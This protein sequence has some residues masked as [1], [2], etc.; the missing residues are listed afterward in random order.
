MKIQQ[1]S[2]G[3]LF[4]GSPGQMTMTKR[5]IAVSFRH[6]DQGQAK[7]VVETSV[8]KDDLWLQIL[9]GFAWLA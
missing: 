5:P 2:D 3:I 8:R 9:S 4:R 6:E 7:V 1:L